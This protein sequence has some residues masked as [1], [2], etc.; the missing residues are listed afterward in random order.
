MATA[1]DEN[2][3]HIFT[4]NA[5]NVSEMVKKTQAETK[6]SMEIGILYK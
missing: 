6:A 1:G 5:V 4:P 3:K 2:M